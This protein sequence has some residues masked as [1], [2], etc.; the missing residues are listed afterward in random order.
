MTMAAPVSAH[1]SAA[2]YDLTKTLSAEATLK[3]FRWSAPHSAV[4]F[5]IK[6]ADG[7]PQEVSMAS[8]SPASLIRQGFKPRDFKPGE[9]M[10]ITWHPSKNGAIGGTL[11][12]MKLSDGRSFNDEEFGPG[13]FGLQDS[14][15]QAE[16]AQ[17]P[18]PA[19]R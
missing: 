10:K 13:G 19:A 8:A 16:S 15:Q 7:K 11:K 1:H 14:K 9:K 18:Q 6:G 5:V 12:T 17:V 2:G 3:E 4:V